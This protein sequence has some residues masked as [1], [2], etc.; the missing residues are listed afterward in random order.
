MIWDIH[1]CWNTFQ[2]LIGWIWEV[3][4]FIELD[5]DP[6]RTASISSWVWYDGE[7]GEQWSAPC[8][9]T[10]A[11]RCNRKNKII[12]YFRLKESIVKHVV[13][14]YLSSYS[15]LGSGDGVSSLVSSKAQT[16]LYTSTG[17][18]A[19]ID[20]VSWFSV[21]NKWAKPPRKFTYS[22]GI[23]VFRILRKEI[24]LIQLTAV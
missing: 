23:F 16:S 8:W 7:V 12:I 19:I 3:W 22:H 13:F 6:S 10:A 2:F 18:G 4:S 14:I 17:W 11:S 5:Y 9:R 1:L 21:W 15:V 24:I 20:D